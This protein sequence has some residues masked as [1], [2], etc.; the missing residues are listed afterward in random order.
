MAK[1]IHILFLF[2][3]FLSGCGNPMKV[4]LR[5]EANT[6]A[7]D[8]FTV[9]TL[10]VVKIYGVGQSLHSIS[11]A[12]AVRGVVSLSTLELVFVYDGR[13][14]NATDEAYDEVEDMLTGKMPSELDGLPATVLVRTDSGNVRALAKDGEAVAV[15]FTAR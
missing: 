11:A 2:A 3:L 10:G 1:K 12:R 15:T 14:F 8:D 9:D 13:S 4:S 5:P 7:V 6:L